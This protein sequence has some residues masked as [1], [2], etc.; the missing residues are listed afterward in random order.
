MNGDTTNR[1][2]LDCHYDQ[3]ICKHAVYVYMHC[4]SFWCPYAIIDSFSRSDVVSSIWSSP[5]CILLK[6]WYRINTL[7]NGLTFLSTSLILLEF[8]SSNGQPSTDQ[9]I[10]SDPMHSDERG[11]KCQWKASHTH[12]I[13]NWIW[14]KLKTKKFNLK[15]NKQTL[16]YCNQ[17]RL[18]LSYRIWFC[19]FPH[20]NVCGNE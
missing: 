17:L 1:T 5:C 16:L 8:P 7:C 20:F 12:S 10:D 2:Q 19:C 15:K 6:V 9:S 14:R 13:T 18:C 4:V 3:L 11:K